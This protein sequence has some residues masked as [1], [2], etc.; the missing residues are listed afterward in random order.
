MR[1]VK[2]NSKRM[3]ALLL[4]CVLCINL[5]IGAGSLQRAAAAETAASGVDLMNSASFDGK[6][7]VLSYDVNKKEGWI[8]GNGS[9][10]STDQPAR[11]FTYNTYGDVIV[12]G[13]AVPLN[14]R[15]VTYSV[16]F[17]NIA[18]DASNT[19]GVRAQGVILQLQYNDGSKNWTLE[20]RF[21]AQM[22]GS[23]Q[24]MQILGTGSTLLA[25]NAG[26][27]F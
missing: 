19:S 2:H 13:V 6:A 14:S 12:D 23:G 17:S 15:E 7:G 16:T 11:Y 1:T 5:F 21:G 27:P 24:Y 25:N 4:V 3:L 20:N 26:A 18:Y 10:A 9:T 22:Y 8:G